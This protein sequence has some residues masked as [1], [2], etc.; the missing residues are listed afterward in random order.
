[1]GLPDDA[2]VFCCFNN[3]YKISP[4]EFD[5]WMRLLLSVDASVLWLLKFNQRAMDN[6]RREAAAR[7]VDPDRLIFANPVAPPQHLARHRLA[8]LFLDTFNYNAHTTAADAFWAG[9]PLVTR[10]GQGFPARVAASLLSVIGLPE[11]I[12]TNTAD[13]EA[14]CLRLATNP[15]QLSAV[16]TKLAAKISSAPLFDTERF[17]RGLETAYDAAYERYLSGKPPTTIDL[18]DPPRHSAG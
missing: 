9:L 18:A 1:M 12:T 14:L 13:Y 3:A 8:D 6:L 17:A 7:G 16:K 11:L 15:P 10:A 4:E 2:F 5:V